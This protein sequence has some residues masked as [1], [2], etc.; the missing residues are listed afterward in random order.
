MNSPLAARLGGRRK[1]SI[2]EDM[3]NYLCSTSPKLTKDV[4]STSWK[5]PRLSL[6]RR[7][8]ELQSRNVTTSGSNGQHQ[9]SRQTQ[10]PYQVQQSRMKRMGSVD[11]VAHRQRTHEP[12]KV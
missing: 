10:T 9:D 12:P 7:F 3:E 6:N 5:E 8:I 11:Q 4:I 2:R 1:E